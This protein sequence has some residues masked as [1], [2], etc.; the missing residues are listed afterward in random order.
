MKKLYL[1]AIAFVFTNSIQ[2]QNYTPLILDSLSSWSWFFDPEENDTIISETWSAFSYDPN[3]RLIQTRNPTS[4]IN[5]AYGVDTTYLMSE[6]VAMNGQWNNFSRST[7]IFQNGQVLTKRNERY[8][9]NLWEN[10]ALYSYFYQGPGEDTLLLLQ[11]WD[12]LQW[13]NFYKKEKTFSLTGNNTEE[14]EYYADGNSELV[15]N[16]GKLFE[17]NNSNQLIAEIGVNISVNGP[18]YTTEINR[19]YNNDGLV[20]SIK[21]CDFAYPNDGTCKNA[22]MTTYNYQN[23]QTIIESSFRWKDEKWNYTGKTL[24]FEGP[25]IYSNLPDSVLTYIYYTDSLTNLLYRRQYLLYEEIEN[26]TVYFKKEEYRYDIPSNEW[27]L[28]KRQEEWYH[29][30]EV[31]HTEKVFANPLESLTMFPNPCQPG[32]TLNIQNDLQYEP[33]LEIFIFDTK[34]Q[35]IS[36]NKLDPQASFRAPYHEGVYTFLVWQNGR[37]I[38][39]SKQV[40]IE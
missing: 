6:T 5:Y 39:T 4:R 9:N 34:A 19:S 30:K 24:T 32:Q 13:V 37:L 33:D 16:R 38:G 1:L 20:D 8:Q 26:D 14:A 10:S 23:P 28:I 11:H 12:N 3:D 17:Y 29:I 36:V 31:V 27:L 25:E 18:Y 40:V 21:R 35:L 22:F 2:S 15:Y 7:T